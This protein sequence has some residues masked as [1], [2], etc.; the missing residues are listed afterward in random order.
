MRRI[1]GSALVQSNTVEATPP[2]EIPPSR[3]KSI[4]LPKFSLTSSALWALSC[5]VSFAEAAL[6][7]RFDK[8]GLSVWG[9]IHPEGLWDSVGYCAVKTGGESG[10]RKFGSGGRYQV[11]EGWEWHSPCSEARG[12]WVDSGFVV[13]F[14]SLIRVYCFPPPGIGHQREGEI[15]NPHPATPTHDGW[16]SRTCCAIP[17]D[18]FS[19]NH[20]SSD[21]PWPWSTTHKASSTWIL[22]RSWF[23]YD[24]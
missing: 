7:Y 1:R 10:Y 19:K 14:P 16:R 11:L 6:F 17:S 8:E 13:R 24:V 12:W 3:I 5:P 9:F 23:N 4:F 2:G 15:H 20:R 21:G 18:L 22:G